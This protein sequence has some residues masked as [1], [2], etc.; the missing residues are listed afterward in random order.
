MQTSTV[1]KPKNS[2]GG[3][4]YVMILVAVVVLGIFSE[5][6]TCYVSRSRQMDREAPAVEGTPCR[7]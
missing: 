3:F 4:T 1:G 7:Q 5:V 6:A 2:Q